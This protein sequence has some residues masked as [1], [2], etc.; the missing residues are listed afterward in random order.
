MTFLIDVGGGHIDIELSSIPKS[1]YCCSVSLRHG[2]LTLLVLDGKVKFHTNEE[3]SY[4]KFMSL[5]NIFYNI[6]SI[7]DMTC[8]PQ[9]IAMLVKQKYILNPTRLFFFSETVLN[10][11]IL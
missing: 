1:F 6:A 7:I 10:K 5:S 2:I 11:Q 9:L 8:N 4:A 3:A